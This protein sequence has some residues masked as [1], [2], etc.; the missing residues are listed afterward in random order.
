MTE[1]SKRTLV[2]IP[3]MMCDARLYAPQIEAFGDAFNL[4]IPDL[5]DG[6]TISG[7]TDYILKL[8]PSTFALLG[9]SMGGIIAMEV[10]R[11][12]S[13]RVER[14]ALLDTNPLA[15]KDNVKQKRGPQ[16]KAVQEGGLA[17]IMRDEMI[18]NYLADPVKNKQIAE[19]CLAMAVGLGKDVF[20]NQSRALMGR[21][22]QTQTLTT[23]NSPAPMP[24]LILCGRHDVL[25]P[26][27]RHELM[28]DLM[29]HATFE[30]IEDAGHLPVLEQPEMTNHAIANWLKR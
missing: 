23:A 27:A 19:L 9:L 6:D 18:P 26:L 12:A 25:C 4:I 29:P 14:I 8:A 15:E 3:G 21:P 11:Q 28:H 17:R 13:E 30:I 10:L 2:M 24:A 20:I 1:P 22:D 16:M 7:Y 5:T